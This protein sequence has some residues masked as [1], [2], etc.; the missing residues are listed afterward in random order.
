MY[1]EIKEH[2]KRLECLECG[3]KYEYTD[4][5]HPCRVCRIKAN[6]FKRAMQSVEIKLTTI[7]PILASRLN[8]AKN[9]CTTHKDYAG[10]GIKVCK[11]WATNTNSFIEWALKGGY[12]NVT[13]L[14]IDREDN[15]GDYEPTNVRFVPKRVNMSNRR[16]YKVK[17]SIRKESD[18]WRVRVANKELGRF[19]SYDVAKQ[20]LDKEV[21]R[22]NAERGRELY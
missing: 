8:S 12:Y 11:E 10:R 15:N 3:T 9:R 13:N 14:E 7:Y 19:Y 4:K 2:Y 21:K 17:G 16:Q 1:K 22:V 5:N 6:E 20:V 18:K